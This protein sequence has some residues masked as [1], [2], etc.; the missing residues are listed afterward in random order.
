LPF[1]LPAG[2]EFFF[3]RYFAVPSAQ[4]EYSVAAAT[5]TQKCLWISTN[6]K[7]RGGR[8]WNRDNKINRSID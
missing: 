5:T 4:I 1:L 7:R 6:K 8:E 3:L 2:P